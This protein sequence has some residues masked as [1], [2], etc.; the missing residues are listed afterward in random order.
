MCP[1]GGQHYGP[2]PY[3]EGLGRESRGQGRS[4]LEALFGKDYPSP[5]RPVTTTL[6]SSSSSRTI[7]LLVL[8]QRVQ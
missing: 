4:Q 7:Q 2:F 1:S 5:R 6:P 3:D 8:P